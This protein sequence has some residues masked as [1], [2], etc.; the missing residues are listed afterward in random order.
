MYFPAIQI[1]PSV[2]KYKLR[3]CGKFQINFPAPNPKTEESN[4]KVI[5]CIVLKCSEEIIGDYQFNYST[6]DHQFFIG[7]TFE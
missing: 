4:S 2:Q 3:E 1:V 5:E 6:I 7:Q